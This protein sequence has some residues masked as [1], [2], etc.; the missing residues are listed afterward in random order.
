MS[1]ARLMSHRGI[2]YRATV[3]RDELQDDV[4]SWAPLPA[5]KGLNCRPDQDWSGT[6]QDH[7]PGEEQAGARRWFLLPGFQVEERDVLSVIAGDNAPINLKIQ[8]VTRCATA[9]KLHHYEVNVEVWQG[10]LTEPAVES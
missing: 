3:T 2:V 7:G 8:S 5:P 10:S 6:L 1:Y 9:R 4:E